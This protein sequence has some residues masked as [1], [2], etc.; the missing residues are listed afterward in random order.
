MLI[1]DIVKTSLIAGG[2]ATASA[3]GTLLI[4]NRKKIK[5]EITQATEEAIEDA[6]E[7]IF[8]D[9]NEQYQSEV[10][11]KIDDTDIVVEEESK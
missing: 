6:D 9:L 2:V 5:E 8:D 3:F 7:I 4:K 11:E 10:I 1:K